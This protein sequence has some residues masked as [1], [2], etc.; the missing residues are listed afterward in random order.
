[1]GRGTDK[2]FER[3]G[4]P[5]ISGKDADKLAQD[6]NNRGIAGVRFTAVTFTPNASIFEKEKCG[7][8]DIILTD[9]NALK[10]VAM[11]FHL[12]DALNR[13]FPGK[14]QIKDIDRLLGDPALREDF[15]KKLPVSDM[16]K[17]YKGLDKMFMSLRKKHLLY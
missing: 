13:L 5:W 16:V 10:P 6:L 9:R 15:E 7:G 8:C 14:F 12:I 17:K 4:A 1:V 11:G 3:F 2:P